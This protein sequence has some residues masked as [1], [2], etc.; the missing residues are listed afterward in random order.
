MMRPVA[1]I[2][3]TLV[4]AGCTAVPKPYEGRDF[5]AEAPVRMNVGAVMVD[6]AYKPTGEWPNV[7]HQLVP[8]PEDA[9]RTAIMQRYQPARPGVAGGLVN[10]RFTIKEASVLEEKLPVPTNWWT[11]QTS[12]APEF[13]YTGRLVVESKTEGAHRRGGYVNAEAA[14]ALDVAHMSEAE[15]ARHV[16]GMVKQ[17]I[18]DVIN[19]LDEQIN[20]NL[21]HFVISGPDMTI[22]PQPSGRWDKVMNWR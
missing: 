2:A 19:Q 6:S 16:G 5:A 15:R 17:M 21:G 1:V 9:L 3:L 4:L 7:E 13:R 8:Q 10:L 20:G 22:T 14:R 12:K 18:D 11:R